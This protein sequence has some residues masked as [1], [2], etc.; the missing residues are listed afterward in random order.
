MMA[1]STRG[2]DQKRF[3]KQ[4]Y[5]EWRDMLVA[6]IPDGPGAIVELGAG[7]QRMPPVAPRAVRTDVRPLPG[8]TL[9][10]DA[11]RLPFRDAS[12]KAMVMT[13]V[14]HHVPDVERFL[15]DVTRALRPGGVMAMVEPWHTAWSRF[16]FQTFHH[17]RFDPRARA[18][19]FPEGDPMEAAN[20]A[21]PWMVFERDRERFERQ[22]PHLRLER[23]DPFMPLRYLQSG[24]IRF[25]SLQ[26][27]WMFPVWTS[28]ERA[29]GSI[30]RRCAMFA[31]IVLRRT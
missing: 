5:A 25:P 20:G 18:W 9:A 24:G 29:A 14:F 17:E 22:F 10:A 30:T 3:L 16:V 28:L 19:A 6:T 8:L 13:D 12:V 27:G 11:R 1:D 7:D 2:L 26:P 21:L 15:D 4:I 31:F 23:I